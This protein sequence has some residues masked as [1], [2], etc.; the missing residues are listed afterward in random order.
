M[1]EYTRLPRPVRVRSWGGWVR[2]GIKV[3]IRKSGLYDLT[4]VAYSQPLVHRDTM[5]VT[6]IF[7]VLVFTRYSWLYEKGIYHTNPN[8]YV[9][10]T[11]RE[12][13]IF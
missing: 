7:S 8:S 4:R 2:N 6:V 10:S 11:T 9:D 3:T 12:A 1:L 13:L 5:L